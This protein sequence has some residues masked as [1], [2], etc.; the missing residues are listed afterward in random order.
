MRCITLLL[1]IAILLFGSSNLFLKAG[2][3]SDAVDQWIQTKMG[4]FD[5]PGLSLVVPKDGKIVKHNS[6]GLASIEFDVPVSDKTVF[7]IASTTKGFTGVGIMML[8]E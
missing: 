3:N 6:Y 7:Q 5:V 4:E 1:F 2:T 8:V